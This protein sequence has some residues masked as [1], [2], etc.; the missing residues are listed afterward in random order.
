MSCPR[1][2]TYTLWILCWSFLAAT[3]CNRKLSPQDVEKL[4]ADLYNTRPYQTAT[5]SYQCTDG[6]GDFDYICQARYE[7]TPLGTRQGVKTVTQRI[8]LT[9]AGLYGGKLGGASMVLPAEGP[10]PSIEQLRATQR[11]EYRKLLEPL[12][13]RTATVAEL[14]RVPL[15][16]K[17][18]AEQIYAGVRAGTITRVDDL[19]KIN[20]IDQPR[21]SV[22]RPRVRW[23]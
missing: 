22:I 9:H 11:D 23:E 16:D 19:S 4:L 15:V 2:Q 8:G 17:Y 20:G 21:F 7:P 10:V 12:N 3:A 14:Q 6:E 18:L 13:L 5:A 1:R